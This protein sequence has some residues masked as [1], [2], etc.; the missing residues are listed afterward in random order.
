MRFPWAKPEV[1]EQ[2][3]AVTPSGD[4]SKDLV[5]LLLSNAGGAS[6]RGV[7][8]AIEIAAGMWGRAFATA[9]V[10]PTN[11]RTEGLNA[12]TLAAIGRRLLIRGSG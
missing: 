10:S 1:L 2:R 5:A 7:P 4:Y 9:R 6:L 8:A 3:Q 12:A 11:A